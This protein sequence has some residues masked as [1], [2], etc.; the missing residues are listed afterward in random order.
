MLKRLKTFDYHE[1][2]IKMLF[3]AKSGFIG[4]NLIA[5]LFIVLLFKDF[6][7][8][9]LLFSWLFLQIAVFYLRLKVASR[10]LKI[11]A[12]D[13]TSKIKSILKQ[14]LWLIFA[15]AF[16]LGSSSFVVVYN[17]D[18]V[19]I[20]FLSL[21]IMVI[22]TGSLST[23]TPVYH[24][25]FIFITVTLISFIF[26]IFLFTLGNI[27]IFMIITLL[28]Y[29][30]IVLPSS[31]R[32]YNSLATNIEQ[33]DELKEYADNFKYLIDSALEAIVISDENFSIVETNSVAV[34]MFGFKNLEDVNGVSLSKFIPNNN[35]AIK[36]HN[37]L[38]QSV[39]IPYEVNLLKVDGTIFPVLAAGRDIVRDTKKY[40]LTTII[41]LSELKEKEYQMLQQSRLA[42]MGEMISMIAHQWRQP[43]NA[44]AS[45]T[46]NL[47]LK[48]LL[49]NFNL[50]T[51]DGQK[52]QEK[53]FRRELHHINYLVQNLT[54]TIDDFRNFYKPTKSKSVSSLDQVVKKSL[55]IIQASLEN[56]KIDIE[57]SVNAVTKIEIY[58]NEIMQVVLNIFK[59]AQ[60]NF[61]EKQIKT[62][63]I[64]IKINEKILSISD[65]GGGIDEKIIDQIFDPYFSTKHEKNGT[66]LGLYM[67]KMIVENHHTGELNVINKNGGVCFE[68]IL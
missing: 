64:K 5:P 60:D 43:L 48:F 1:E 31:F 54:T 23:L 36:I 56:D 53:Y 58:E 65:N 25:V 63:K 47:D 10:A 9:P 2:L 50:E 66:G 44:I 3:N 4:S 39:A 7:P 67:S 18:I 6:V 37:A 59:N 24:A 8:F 34:S 49:K 32:I 19:Y 68:I 29:I 28:S 57:H 55:N 42:Q 27:Q 12:S 26:G 41:D 35:E 45:R 16:L 20:L 17:V 40:R 61:K 51:K 13:D 14:Y 46:T 15:N 52:E 11:L 30:V 21:A 62:P 33:A 38:S 22:I